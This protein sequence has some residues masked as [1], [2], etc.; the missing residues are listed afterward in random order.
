MTRKCSRC[1][2]EFQVLR[3]DQRR[4][5]QSDRDVARLIVLDNNRRVVRFPARDM[6]AL[7]A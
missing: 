6:T 4:C 7:A 2:A 5:G 1:G 3:V